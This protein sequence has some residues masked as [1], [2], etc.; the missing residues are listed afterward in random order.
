MLLTIY[1]LTFTFVMS[2]VRQQKIESL[3]Q[4]ELASFFLQQSKSRYKGAMIS[5]TQVR[6]T[7][8]L[9]LA[10]IYVSIFGGGKK[11]EIFELIEHQTGEIRMKIAAS[12]KN[13]LRYMPELEFRLDD[14]IDYAMN[15]DKLL[16]RK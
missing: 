8:D 4:R 10:R 14:S 15:I 2:S 3:L 11:E 12:I 13:Q 7:G 6:L 5:V 9:S 1:F 16:K